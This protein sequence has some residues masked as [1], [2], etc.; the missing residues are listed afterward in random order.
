L[1]PG[2]RWRHERGPVPGHPCRSAGIRPGFVY[3]PFTSPVN[4]IPHWSPRLG[5]AWF[6]WHSVAQ[7]RTGILTSLSDFTSTGQHVPDDWEQMR[8][9]FEVYCSCDGLGIPPSVCIEEGNTLGAPVLDNVQVGI[10]AEGTASLE[11]AGVQPRRFALHPSQPNPFNAATMICFDLPEAAH[12]MLRLRDVAGRTVQILV[13]GA[14]GPGSYAV[15]WDGTDA[16][17]DK[18]LSGIYFCT[19]EA[20]SATQTRRLLLAR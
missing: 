15:S 6:T 7:C 5:T 18:V 8:F 12:A 1:G 11:Q 16:T 3:Y 9:T 20:G 10:A 19:L 2:F 4:P 17:G 14:L 13:D